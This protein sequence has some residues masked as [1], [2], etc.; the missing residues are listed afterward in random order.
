VR[1][2]HRS[3]LVGAILFAVVALVVLGPVTVAVLLLRCCDDSTGP[4]WGAWVLLAILV[5]CVMLAAA[6]V[7]GLTA[8]LLRRLV[9]HLRRGS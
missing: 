8:A 7:G 6:V 4:T 5:A 9:S 1:R 2:F 3:T